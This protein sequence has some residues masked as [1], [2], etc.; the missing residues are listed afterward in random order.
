MEKSPAFLEKNPVGY[1]VTVFRYSAGLFP[2]SKTELDQISKSWAAAYKEAWTFS[3]TLD[4]SPM[5]LDRDEGE[6]ACPS[7]VEKWIRAVLEVWEQC[8][9]LPGEISRQAM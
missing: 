4:S 8:I 5:C 6:R 1:V 2:W 7:A 9:G 3:K